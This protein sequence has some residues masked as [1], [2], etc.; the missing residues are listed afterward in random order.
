MKVF[1][2]DTKSDML[3]FIGEGDISAILAHGGA[4]SPNVGDMVQSGKNNLVSL[5]SLDNATKGKT[6]VYSCGAPEAIKNTG[7]YKKLEPGDNT[8][9]H[10]QLSTMFESIVDFF[11][12]GAKDK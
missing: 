5:S 2:A 7:D 8:S 10:P 9:G 3:K 11:F 1:S 6:Y 4:K 12:N